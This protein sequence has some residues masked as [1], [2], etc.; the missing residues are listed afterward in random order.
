MFASIK[1]VVFEGYMQFCMYIEYSKVKYSKIK[2]SIHD[3]CTTSKLFSEW[4]F[5]AINA[6]MHKEW[7]YKYTDLKHLKFIY[8]FKLSFIKHRQH[9]G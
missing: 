3:I 9:G 2:V 4:I 8:I 5:T 7:M 1:G 6:F